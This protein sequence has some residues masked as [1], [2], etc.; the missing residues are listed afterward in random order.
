MKSIQTSVAIGIA[1]LS[2]A[3]PHLTWLGFVFVSQ[4]DILFF[5][6]GVIVFFLSLM[7]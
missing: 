3:V 5:N 1:I 6:N 2:L 4:Y 7:A